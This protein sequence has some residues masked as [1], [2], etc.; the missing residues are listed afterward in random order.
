MDLRVSNSALV[1]VVIG[2]VTKIIQGYWHPVSGQAVDTFYA[3]IHRLEQ[4]LSYSSSLTDGVNRD[5]ANLLEPV[6]EQQKIMDMSG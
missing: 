4:T 6:T 2:F 3:E 5:K 1:K